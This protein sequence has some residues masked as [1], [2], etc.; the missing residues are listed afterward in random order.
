MK[1]LI[2]LP[3]NQARESRI[4]LWLNRKNVLFSSIMEER[5]SNRQAVLVSQ[6]LASFS[7]LSCSFFIHWLAA[8]AC[9]NWFVYSLLLCR[10]GGLR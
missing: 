1:N 10:K 5:V 8:V 2:A 3:V 7:I 9:L 6:V 4:S